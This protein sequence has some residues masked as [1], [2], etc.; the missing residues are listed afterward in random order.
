MNYW[1][2]K[3]DPE[4]YS[5]SD[6]ERDKTTIW[7]GVRNFEARNNLGKMDYGDLAYVYHSIQDKCI[8]GIVEISKIAFPD[9]TTADSSWLAVGIKIIEKL[10]EPIALE[11]LKNH[12]ILQNISLVKRSRL[13]VSPISEMEFQ[14]IKELGK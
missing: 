4:K 5:W 3:T 14:L 1:I 10:S 11:T 9:P 2:I 12:P 8:V 13:S 7:D 6:L